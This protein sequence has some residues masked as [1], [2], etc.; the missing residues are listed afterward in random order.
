[1]IISG[2]CTEVIRRIRKNE[3]EFYLKVYFGFKVTPVIDDMRKGFVMIK[4]SDDEVHPAVDGGYVVREA[5]AKWV[6]KIISNDP[7]YKKFG[8][9]FE[10]NFTFIHRSTKN[11]L[12][13]VPVLE[14]EPTQW[15]LPQQSLPKIGLSLKAHPW[16]AVSRPT[17][18][19]DKRSFMVSAPDWER[20]LMEAH[21]HSHRVVLL[22]TRLCDVHMLDP[23]SFEEVIRTVVLQQ[24][25]NLSSD[26]GN[27][28]I[29]ALEAMADS[30]KAGILKRFLVD[31][32]N[33]LHT[34][35]EV[36][37]ETNYEELS[38]VLRQLKDIKTQAEDGVKEGQSDWKSRLL[39]MF[40]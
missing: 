23:T 37:L 17:I 31:N 27:C 8:F 36:K 1:M 28:L 21:H 3:F 22:L 13:C 4:V 15:P 29:E 12:S 24:V 38:Y 10:G 32:D 6:I 16:Y 11:K 33:V 14:F 34:W 7:E 20:C 18:P 25:L 30:L 19:L 26:L 40:M 9:Y 39:A 2:S 5:L 35:N